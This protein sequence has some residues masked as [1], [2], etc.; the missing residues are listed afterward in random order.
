MPRFRLLMIL[1][2]FALALLPPGAREAAAQA[3]TPAAAIAP[4]QLVTPGRLQLSIN[5]TLPPQQFVDARGELQGLNVELGHEIARRLCLDMAFMRMDFPAMIPG[6]QAGRFDGI[7]T[8]MFW[9]EER[10]RILFLVPYAMQ[11]ISI[12]V[13]ANSSQRF[14]TMDDLAGKAVVVEVN[15]YQERW[16]RAQSEDLV[17]RGKAPI[18]V[19]AFTTATEAMSALRAGQGDAGALIDYMAVDLTRRGVVRIELD[20][21]GGAPSAMAFRNRALAEAVAKVLTEL[22]AEGSYDR[23]FERYGMTPQPADQP[24][25]IRGPGPGGA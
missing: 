19:R 21:L 20:R 15:S 16:L 24:F 3:C 1:V 14:A 10:S 5:P 6:L 12:A 25:G 11:A 18:T 9:T 7:N 23:L 2:G 4:A 17:R 22:R 13:P 8:G